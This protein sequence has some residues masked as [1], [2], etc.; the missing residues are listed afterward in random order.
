MIFRGNHGSSDLRF[1]LSYHFVDR[2][3]HLG[4]DSDNHQ[5]VSTEMLECGIEVYR[6]FDI[7][8]DYWHFLGN[9]ISID[10]YYT[11]LDK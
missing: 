7:K 10:M 3:S 8:K 4:T 2:C 1:L 5:V 9:N 6:K 11:S